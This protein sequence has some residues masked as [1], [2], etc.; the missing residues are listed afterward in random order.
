MFSSGTTG[1]PKRL[2]QGAGVVAANTGM[3]ARLD[4]A[5]A[6]FV[7]E[8]RDSGTCDISTPMVCIKY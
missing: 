1:K 3:Y 6:K 5:V 4:A 7:I 8:P 2:A